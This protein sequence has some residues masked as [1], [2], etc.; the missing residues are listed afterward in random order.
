MLAANLGVTSLAA[1][2][3]P[4]SA[5]THGPT[6]LLALVFGSTILGAMTYLQFSSVV[7]I[8][9]ANFLAL[10]ALAP[11][12]AYALQIVAAWIGLIV[13]PPFEL[14]VLFPILAGIAGVLLIVQT[15][16]GRGSPRGE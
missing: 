3:P 13:V 10:S 5:F 8:G 12:A 16:N 7:K 4:V 14:A 15:G 1:I 11:L 9:T 2:A 6:I